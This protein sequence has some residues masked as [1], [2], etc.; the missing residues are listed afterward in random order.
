MRWTRR[1]SVS[2]VAV[3]HITTSS[4]AEDGSRHAFSTLPLTGPNHD[5]AHPRKQRSSRRIFPPIT[6]N[7]SNPSHPERN[8]KR[9]SELSVTLASILVSYLVI[10]ATQED[11]ECICNMYECGEAGF[12]FGSQEPACWMLESIY[13]CLYVE[14]MPHL[15]IEKC[16]MEVVPSE[17]FLYYPWESRCR[18]TGR[19]SISSSSQQR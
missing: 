16:W 4:E 6:Y 3:E 17:I 7:Q 11:L 8:E 2:S 10:E 5:S 1:H 19:V 12:P 14:D 9:Q 15:G 13:K 18:P